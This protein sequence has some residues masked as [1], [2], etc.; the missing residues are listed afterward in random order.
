MAFVNMQ[1]EIT[2]RNAKMRENLRKTR[3]NEM[4]TASTVQREWYKLQAGDVVWFSTGFYEVADAWWADH[5]TA[6]VQLIIPANN[7][8]PRHIETY[9]VRL[10][11]GKA[12]CRV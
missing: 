5:H 1:K 12:T 10:G 4:A 2:M 11:D 7:I 8:L 6:V 9:R 3:E